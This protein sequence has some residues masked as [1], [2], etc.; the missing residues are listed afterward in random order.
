MDR[1]AATRRQMD[2]RGIEVL[3]VSD[4]PNMNYLTGYNAWSFYVD[5]LVAVSVD[6]PEPLWIGRGIDVP[7]A[8]YSTFLS[9]PD[10]VGY[11][12]DYVYRHDKHPMQFI[13]EVLRERGW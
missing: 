3:L 8:R 6:S 5:Q 10:I 1:I 7:C 11:P 9:D 13:S 12:D 4:P 2:A